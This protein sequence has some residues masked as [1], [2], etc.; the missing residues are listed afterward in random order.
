[1]RGGSTKVVDRRGKDGE[2]RGES[3]RQI[4]GK[5]GEEGGKDFRQKRTRWRGRRR[6]GVDRGE[7][8]WRGRRKDVVDKRMRGR[9]RNNREEKERRSVLLCWA[10]SVCR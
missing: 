4:R 6:E 1:M 10:F 2:E 3:C 9:E 8:R 5:Y 7:K